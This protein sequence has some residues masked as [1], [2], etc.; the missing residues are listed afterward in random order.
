[1]SQNIIRCEPYKTQGWLILKPDSQIVTWVI[2]LYQRVKNTDTSYV[3]KLIKEVEL[4]NNYVQVPDKYFTDKNTY[5]YTVKGLLKG[6]KVGAEEGPI[7]LVP[8]PAAPGAVNYELIHTYKCDGKTYAWELEE[9][10]NPNNNM[11]YFYLTAAYSIVDN[12]NQTVIPYY[13]YMGQTQFSA[14]AQDN[15]R[16]NGIPATDY[17]NIYYIM[18]PTYDHSNDI[19]KISSD[20][21]SYYDEFDQPLSGSP[22]YGVKKS[23]GKWNTKSAVNFSYA[24]DTIELPMEEIDKYVAMDYFN[25]YAHPTDHGLPPLECDECTHPIV[26]L[27]PPAI[28]NIIKDAKSKLIP[29]D[30]SSSESDFYDFVDTVFKPIIGNWWD[31]TNPSGMWI[32]EIN[33]IPID[34]TIQ[35]ID[36]IID[37][38][39]QPNQ[40][41]QSIDIRTKKFLSPN[42]EFNAPKFVLDPGLYAIEF[43]LNSGFTFPIYKEVKKKLLNYYELSHFLHVNAY[44]SPIIDNQFTLHLVADAKLKF[45]YKL[46]D[47]NGNVLYTKI[48]ALQKGHDGTHTIKVHYGIPKGILFHRFIFEDGSQISIE[49]CK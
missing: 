48:F 23:L 28:K 15:A 20:N 35:P 7:D 6:G 5:V 18:Y 38:T 31:S 37:P 27:N 45:D 30:S 4:G 22:I 41:I 33:I 39:T 9:Y 25:A 11:G 34:S 1:M 43:T 10:K 16:V 12:Q 42:K 47:F 24:T 49:T 13:Q 40:I 14:L 8:L 46:V 29:P 21:Q 32:S 19:I 36:I 26:P 17:Y 2:D 44:P 3:D